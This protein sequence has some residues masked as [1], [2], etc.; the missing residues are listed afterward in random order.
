MERIIEEIKDE[1]K[2]LRRVNE[3]LELQILLLEIKNRRLEQGRM[4]KV[5]KVRQVGDGGKF[6]SYFP[7]KK[8]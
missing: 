7:K 4:V 2:R 6:I 1:N 8:V 3:N 5:L